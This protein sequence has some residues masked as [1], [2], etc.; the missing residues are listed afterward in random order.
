VRRASYVDIQCKS[1]LNRV[2]GMP[3]KWSLNPFV[4]CTHSC[5]YCY[6]RAF[7]ALG[8]HG[9]AD[10][11]FETRILVKVNIAEVLRRELR[12]PSWAGEQVAL[13]S[14]TDCYQPVEG[15]YRLT[16]R[17][18]EALRDARNPMS[19]VTKSPLVIR[20]VDILSDLAWSVKVRLFVTVTT[21]DLDVWRAIEPG[22]ANP[23]K[24][25]EVMRRLNAAGV[26]TG[27]L[28]A[29]ILPGITDS[30]ASLNA[31]MSAA[32]DHGARFLGTGTLRLAPD[33]KTHYFG[34]VR[35]AFP[36]L[37][38]RYERAYPGASAPREY[39]RALGARLDRIRARY[40]FD[41]DPRHGYERT[42]APGDG[43]SAPQSPRR[44]AQL[45]LPL[46]TA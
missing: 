5:H 23:W 1:A 40:E 28:L 39:A 42:L 31:V 36:G 44:N 18:L 29:P 27:L 7:Y 37:L 41:E 32:R 15:R 43:V 14:S 33:V 38:A 3:F 22:T 11:D 20:D 8:D 21:V 9:N 10:E 30:A 6:A 26:P 12:R 4:G 19:L 45:R 24:R 2:R 25:F 35:E 16:R 13:G 17:V 46:E 34:F